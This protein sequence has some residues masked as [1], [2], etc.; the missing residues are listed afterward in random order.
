MKSRILLPLILIF[1]F[2]SVPFA[3]FQNDKLIQCGGLLDVVTGEIIDNAQILIK[4]NLI[5][6]VD[7]GMTPL[8]AIQSATVVAAELMGWLDKT[9]SIEEGKYADIIAVEKN[10]LTDISVLQNV[11]FVMKDGKIIKDVT[12][13]D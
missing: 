12:N 6:M 9:G 10:P 11:K 3:F 5:T 4:G 2:S 8:Q 7:Y 13:Q 1:I